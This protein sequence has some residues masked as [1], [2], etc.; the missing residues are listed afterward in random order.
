MQTCIYLSY[1][2]KIRTQVLS[3]KQFLSLVINLLHIRDRTHPPPQRVYEPVA[4]LVAVPKQS[5]IPAV[6]GTVELQA[7]T[8][9]CHEPLHH[10]QHGG[11]PHSLSVD[12]QARTRTGHTKNN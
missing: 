8:H 1:I 3:A 7:P 9:A 2:L 12:Q 11:T 10:A 6:A 4:A 5:H